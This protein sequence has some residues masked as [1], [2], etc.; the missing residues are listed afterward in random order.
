MCRDDDQRRVAVRCE[1]EVAG[2]AGRMFWRSHD[3]NKL[4]NFNLQKFL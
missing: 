4:V 3:H 1:V 2:V